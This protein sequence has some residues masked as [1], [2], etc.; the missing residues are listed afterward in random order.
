MKKECK[1][2]LNAMVGNEERVILRMLE[3]SYKYIDYWVIQCNGSDKTQSIIE[4]FYK[5]K[6]AFLTN[7]P[8]SMNI[9]IRHR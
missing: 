6:I 4:K 2:C 8:R 9:D 5:P 7:D 3:S 1:I